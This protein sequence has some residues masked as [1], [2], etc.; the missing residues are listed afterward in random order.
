[1][2]HIVYAAD[3]QKHMAGIKGSRRTGT[4][5]GSADPLVVQK[6]QERFSLDPLETEIGVSGQA[7]VRISIEGGVRDLE[8]SPDQTI[9]QR[10]LVS[11]VL[12][13]M[14]SRLFQRSCH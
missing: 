13:H 8:K 10:C 2:G 7:P 5:G 6:E 9:P 1:M 11:C 3:G 14:I 12:S 4:A